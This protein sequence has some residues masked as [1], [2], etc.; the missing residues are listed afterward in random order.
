MQESVVH[1]RTVGTLKIFFPLT[2][3]L[4]ASELLRLLS[5]QLKITSRRFCVFLPHSY[6]F[7]ARAC[8]GQS[9]YIGSMF[10]F[11]YCSAVTQNLSNPESVMYTSKLNPAH[12]LRAIKACDERNTQLYAN[13][14]NTYREVRQ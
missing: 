6:V 7:Q 13:K 11:H 4:A 3:F 8:K 5:T 14:K 12:I 10:S 1:F 9:T 2:F